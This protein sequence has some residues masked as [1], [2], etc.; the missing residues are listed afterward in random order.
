MGNNYTGLAEL[1]KSN[2]DYRRTVYEIWTGTAFT[3]SNF[4]ILFSNFSHD[5]TSCW[6]Q[7][8]IVLPYSEFQ[9]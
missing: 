1:N 6:H 5:R 4:S 2:F 3:V 7:L 9:L 8:L